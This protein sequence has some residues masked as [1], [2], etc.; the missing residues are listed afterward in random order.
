MNSTLTQEIADVIMERPQTF[1]VD[2]RHFYLYPPTLGKLYLTQRLLDHAGMRRRMLQKNAAVECLRLARDHR[3][4][5]LSVIAYAT[6]RTHDDIMSPAA[7][8]ARV[9]E[10]RPLDESDI[11]T[12]LVLII[13]ADTTAK[14][15][16]ELGI[17]RDRERMRQVMRAKKSDDTYAFGGVSIYGMLLDAACSRYGWT[18]EYVVWGISYENLRLMLADKPDTVY[19]S[20]EERKHCHVAHRNAVDGNDADAMKAFIK[21]QSW[22]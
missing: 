9:A 19:L 1:D 3:D 5:C 17:T 6:L 4:D 11:A 8:K 18:L 10:L 14:H 13:T 15:M 20:K 7:V 12:L 2:G 22:K 16:D 21:S